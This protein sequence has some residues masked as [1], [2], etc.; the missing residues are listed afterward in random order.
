MTSDQDLVDAPQVLAVAVI[1]LGS[2]FGDGQSDPLLRGHL[3]LAPRHVRF[4]FYRVHNALY[5]KSYDAPSKFHIIII[6]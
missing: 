3:A 5:T 1:V 4:A 6:E 2:V